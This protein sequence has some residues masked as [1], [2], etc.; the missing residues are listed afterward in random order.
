[1]ANGKNTKQSTQTTTTQAAAP[2]PVVA[3]KA[4]K[5][6]ASKK[7][8]KK[9]EVVATPA[10][11]VAPVAE[12]KSSSKKTEKTEKKEEAV[13]APV[14]AVA[15]ESEEKKARRQVSKQ[16]VYDDFVQL[17]TKIQEEIDKR[18][19]AAPVAEDGAAS[20]SKK[21]KRKK[22]VGVPVKFLRS[23]NKRLATLQSDATKMMKLKTKTTRNNE[24]SG[25][26]KP[27]K[28]SDTLF[29]F[30]KSTGFEIEKDKKYPRVEITKNIH[31]YVSKND[32]RDPAD[33]RTII[34]DAKLAALLNYDAATAENK[35]TYFR[36]PQYLKSHFISEPKA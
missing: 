34:P 19:P 9:E 6:A 12:K 28:I 36:L 27:V 22:D 17:I 10:P 5:K 31:Q 13:A 7:T 15:E 18:A 3:D 35:M 33:K 20:A 23:I 8:E 4:D 21:T 30:L 25:L 24:N 11:V 16:S 29:N 32:L 1:M 14:E 2:A 26:M